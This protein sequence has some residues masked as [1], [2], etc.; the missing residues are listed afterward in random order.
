MAKVFAV[1]GRRRVGNYGE[2]TETEPVVVPDDVGAELAKD[3]NGE[4]RVERD[5]PVPKP[6]KAQEE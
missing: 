6:R 3:P 1:S 5:A 2:A 4:V